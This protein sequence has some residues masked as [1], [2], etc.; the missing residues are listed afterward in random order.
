MQKRRETLE[1]LLSALPETERRVVTMRWIEGKSWKE[2]AYRIFTCERNGQ[3][4]QK[5]G[6]ERMAAMLSALGVD[7][8]EV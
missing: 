7:Q 2:V 6:I 3:R 8:K 5:R 4:I 1:M